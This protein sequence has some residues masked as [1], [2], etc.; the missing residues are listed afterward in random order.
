MAHLR[1]TLLP[2][3]A[4]LPL[5]AAITAAAFGLQ[6]TLSRPAPGSALALEVLARLE[7]VR[8]LN[9]IL[10]L[11]GHQGVPVSCVRRD[12]ARELVLERHL[13]HLIAAAQLAPAPTGSDARQSPDGAAV[14]LAGCPGLLVDDLA[15]RLVNGRPTLPRHTREPDG[16]PGYVLRIAGPRPTVE[17]TVTSRRCSRFA[18]T[19]RAGASPLTAQSSGS[20]RAPSPARSDRDRRRATS[21]R[22]T[23]GSR[24]QGGP[25]GKDRSCRRRL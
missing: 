2:L 5:T 16:R 10:E 4:A 9:S 19:W 14:D 1:R 22:V 7:Q 20:S 24:L 11:P 23:T 17:L 15:T 12:R 25:S 18:S 21:L 6:A 8:A 13:R 3:L